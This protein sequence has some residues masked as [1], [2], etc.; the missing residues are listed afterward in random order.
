MTDYLDEVLAT[1]TPAAPA[2]EITDVSVTLG[3]RL[4]LDSVSLQ[5]D[6]GEVVVVV[7][8]NGA[9]KSTLLAV[10]AGD[11]KPDS[12]EVFLDGNPLSQLRPVE[13]S[14]LRA[15]L[16]QENRTSFPF[17]A[18]QVVQM[19]RR[20]WRGTPA[21]EQDEIV[22]DSAMA[23]T[24]VAHLA[25]RTFPTLSGGEKAR[26]SFARTLAQ[27]T[28][29]HILDEPTAALDI[30][31]QEILLEQAK[32]NARSGMAVIVVL[33]D[34]TCA[35]AYADRIVMLSHGR[36]RA[37]GSPR[38]VMTSELLSEVYE[39]PVEVIDRNDGSGPIIVPVRNRLGG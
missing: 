26:T 15:V 25:H 13:Q 30:H 12:G 37:V 28:M 17:T 27:G 9:G 6:V 29:V 39:H 7:G 32:H 36:V 18:K 16:L 19:G 24:E 1:I 11:R 2:I 34:L 31:H 22:I 4:V 38:E 33:H 20:P 14:R 3:D 5:F 8:P 35:A 21:E 10:L 23:Y